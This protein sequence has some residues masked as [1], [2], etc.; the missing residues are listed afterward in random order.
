MREGGF[1]H[2]NAS[3]SAELLIYVIARRNMWD[4]RRIAVEFAVAL[5]VVLLAWMGRWLLDASLNGY[6]P[7]ITFFPAMFLLALWGGFRPTSFGVL[8]SSLLIAYLILEP[9]NSFQIDA[10]ELRVGL[11]LYVAVS[12]AAG[13]LGSKLIGANRAA[14]AAIQVALRE[15]ERQ[16]LIAENRRR[17]EESLAF[18]AHASTSLAALVDRES[19]LQQAARL[20]IPFLADWCVVYVVDGDGDIEYHAHAH[21]DA[22]KDRLLGEML[23][24]FPLDWSSNTATVQA[25]RTGQSQL[26]AELPE[27]LLSSFT[28]TDEHREMVAQLRPHAVISVP[29]KIRDRTIGVIGLVACEPE[30]RYTQEE[31]A[32]AENLAERVAVAVDNAR[33]FYAVKE[34]S[35]QKDEFLAMLAH[36]LRNPLAAIRYAVL[37]GQLAPDQSPAETLGII[38]RQTG[39]LAHLIDDLLDVSRISRDKITLRR[40]PTDVAAVVN[41]AAATV[42]PLLEEKR[43]SLSLEIP[44]SPIALFV[45][46]TRTEQIL[47]NLLTNAAK[48]TNHEGRITVRCRPESHQAI[49]EV[50]DT[51]IGLPPEL[52]TRVFDLFAQA[53]RTLD[54]AEGG[55]GIGL[56]VARKLAELHGGTIE[57]HSDGVGRGSTFTVRLPLAEQPFVRDESTSPN[58]DA[59]SV[60]R[61]K[62]LVVDDNRDTATSCASIFKALGHEVQTAFDGFA[63]LET[64]RAFHPE[65]IFLDIGLPG[66]NG[67]DVAR[68]L[69]SEGFTKETIVAVSGYGQPDDRQRSR[70]AGF[71]DHL[72]KPVPHED[73]LGVLRRVH[74]KQPA[75]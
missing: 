58:Y 45:D 71:D 7:F 25:L 2:L 19:A 74:A 35:R 57:A 48:Y 29:L 60:G 11:C 37:L 26:M 15:E 33:L 39:N 52:L 42:R 50:I 38:D 67:F 20:P 21:V 30:R 75:S 32:L 17:T 4:R 34:A 41:A 53:D 12:L 54:R 64:A 8:L 13:W 55:L 28:Q 6:L 46:P 63:A 23:N 1:R 43:H 68:T 65:A 44:A 27:P 62:I 56:T 47:A 24:K 69:R 66:I 31:V 40:R 5:A 51:G 72:V 49:I 3:F 61:R 73:L 36:E 16:R 22:A 14:Q 18:L 70:E 10:L 59:G 9:V